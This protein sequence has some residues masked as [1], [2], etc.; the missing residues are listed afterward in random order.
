LIRRHANIFPG[1]YHFADG[2][3]HEKIAA[4][5]AARVT[6]GDIRISNLVEAPAGT[7]TS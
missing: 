5:R 2:R 6:L 1:F 3:V 4:G 7:M